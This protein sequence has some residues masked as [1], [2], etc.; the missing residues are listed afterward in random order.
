MPPTRGDKLFLSTGDPG[1]IGEQEVAGVVHLHDLDVVAQAEA[2]REAAVHLP[3]VLHEHADFRALDEEVGH[4]RHA[5][6][7]PVGI[8]PRVGRVEVAVARGESERAVQVARVEHVERQ[9]VVARAEL[10]VVVA[11]LPGMNHENVSSS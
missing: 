11:L 6:R 10:H 1:R 8:G 4:A 5:D 2:R 3:L 9:V 7:E